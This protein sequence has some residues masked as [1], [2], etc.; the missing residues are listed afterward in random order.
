MRLL[1]NGGV[2]SLILKN[3]DSG[4]SLP[5]VR[6]LFKSVTSQLLFLEVQFIRRMSVN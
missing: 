6:R 1:G 5:D 2:I 4:V 3:I